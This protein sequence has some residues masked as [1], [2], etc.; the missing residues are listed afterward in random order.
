MKPTLLRPLFAFVLIFAPVSALLAQTQE[1]RLVAWN[2]EHLA[3]QNG[4]GCVPRTDQEYARLRSFAETLEADVVALQEVESV[5]AVARVFPEEEWDI[6]LSERAASRSYECRGSGNT[7]TQ[8]RVAIAVRKGISYENVGSFEELALEM[9]GLR[10]GV[11]IRLLGPQ[12]TVEVMAVHLKSGCFVDD[13]ST[14]DRRACDVLER[15]VPVLDKW[16]EDR[17]ASGTQF[18]LLGDFNHRLSTPENKLWQVLTEMDD[19]PVALLNS[20][21]HLEGCHPR[22]PKPIDHIIMGPKAA[23]LYVSGSE[24]VHY[25]QSQAQEMTE[26]E[27][28]S[29]HCPISVALELK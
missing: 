26:E 9:E 19:Q 11:V 14:S 22:Y 29:D 23:N 25:Y 24:A 21:Q 18:V 4:T 5:G 2:I 8:Q 1:L 28:L 15:Q 16:I 3:E 6:I 17:I 12:D 27:M 7:S 13:Y 10:Y 20:M